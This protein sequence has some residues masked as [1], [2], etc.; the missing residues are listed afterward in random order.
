[1]TID[2]SLTLVNLLSLLKTLRKAGFSRTQAVD[3]LD[4]RLLLSLRFSSLDK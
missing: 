3:F 1:M 4:T 2:S